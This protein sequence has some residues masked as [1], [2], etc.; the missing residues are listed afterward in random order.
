MTTGLAR[1]YEPLRLRG[2]TLRNRFIKSATYEGESTSDGPGEAVARHHAR[3]AE[4]GVALTT[5][6]YCAVEPDGRTFERQT[7]L[8]TAS[9]PALQRLTEGVHAH[10]GAVGAQL[11]H[12]GYFTRS[13]ALST[14]LPRGPSL[15]LNE[16]GLASG[17]PLALA[18]AR[19]EI[20]RIVEAF[21]RGARLA[22][23]A[24]FDAV[25]I[26][27]GHGYLLS[28][29]ISPLTNRRHDDYGGAIEA[30]MRLPLEVVASVRAAVGARVPILAKTN[31][32]DGVR[33]GLTIDDAATGAAM[34]ER[35]GV[36]ALVLSGGFTSKSPFFLLRGA[37]PLASMIAHEPSALQRVALRVF[38][39]S[40]VK[41]VPFEPLFFLTLAE[42]IRSRV[43]MPLAYLGGVTGADD[44]ATVMDRGFE[45][46]ALARPLLADP[47]MVRR[48]REEGVR[49]ATRC[50]RCNECVARMDA[51]GGVACVRAEPA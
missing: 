5:L 47:S 16:Y 30:R 32:S 39:P 23:E 37:R 3:L 44:V 19:E 12:A 40:V 10:G 11:A 36:D 51:P 7:V 27:M 22:V 9:M 20:A 45:L 43:G 21:G 28:Q 26:H 35:A 2:L 25:E 48:M 4:G 1:A 15:G 34:L 17:K 41:E 38:G 6:A 46:C 29:F 18:L 31:L 13:R 50:N 33:G 49:Y 42:A 14:W 8:S 24:G